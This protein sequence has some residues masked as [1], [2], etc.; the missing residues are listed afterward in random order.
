MPS[1]CASAIASQ[2]WR[3]KSTA[4]STGSGP[5]C[6]RT[7]ARGRPPAGTPSPCK[8]SRCRACRRRAR[9]P[10][11]RSGS[12]RPP[13]GP[14]GRTAPPPRGCRASI[15]SRNLIATLVRAASAAR[16]RRRPFRRRPST[17]STRYLPARISPS[18]TPAVRRGSSPCIGSRPSAARTN[19]GRHRPTA[20]GASHPFS[21][22]PLYRHLLRQFVRR[23]RRRRARQNK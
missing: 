8:A 1:V 13:G 23:A 16:R 4:S 11:A 7:R 19:R 2:A 10:R 20:R 17:R 18:R 21:L 3:R 22:E 15:G 9:A 14:R 5:R 12:S 6:R